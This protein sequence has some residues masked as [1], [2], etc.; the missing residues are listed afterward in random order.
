MGYYGGGLG[1]DHPPQKRTNN[2]VRLGDPP[3]I[4]ISSDQGLWEHLPR[5]GPYLRSPYE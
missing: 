3:W 1:S 5:R 4:K 2:V